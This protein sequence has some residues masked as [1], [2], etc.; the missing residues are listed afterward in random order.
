MEKDEQMKKEQK[1][2][3]ELAAMITDR[4]NI[5]GVFVAVNP[6]VAYGWHANVLTAPSQVVRCQQLVEQIAA[7]LREKYDLKS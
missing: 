3:K 1:T 5:G 2:S 6:D 7:E 4:I